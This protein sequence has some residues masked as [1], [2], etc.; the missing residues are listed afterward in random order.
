MVKPTVQYSTDIYTV[1]IDS[2]QDKTDIEN[3]AVVVSYVMRTER[4]Q[5]TGDGDTIK[6]RQVRPTA[7]LPTSAAT[8]RPSP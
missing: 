7:R 4:E 1:G 6:C 3:V 8:A 2:N 5:G